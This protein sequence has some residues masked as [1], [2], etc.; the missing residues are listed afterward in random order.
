MFG[1]IPQKSLMGSFLY[2]GCSALLGITV[3]ILSHNTDGFAEW[4]ANYIYPAF[5][6]TIGRLM[7]PIPFSV[8]E[9]LLYIATLIVVVYL[10]Y[11]LGLLVVP[12]FRYGLKK[13]LFR[14]LRVFLIA[15]CTL[16]MLAS[17]TTLVHY[18]RDTFADLTEREIAPAS[19]EALLELG[20]ILIADLAELEEEI[21]TDRAGR[22]TLGTLDYRNESR[23]AM[24]RIRNEHQSLDGFY[25]KPKP[26]FFSSFMSKMGLTGMFSPFTIEANYNAHVPDYIIPFTIC[27]ELAHVRGFLR[28][29][30]AGFIAYLACKRSPEPEFRYS[31]ALNALTYVLRAYYR[32]AT[33][34]EY[35]A[36]LAE[37]PEQAAADIAA[38][39]AYWREFRGR[40]SD[41]ANRANDAYLRVNA[42]NDGV[43]SYGRMIDLLLAEYRLSVI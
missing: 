30:E 11:L 33:I 7:S 6:D 4:Y 14:G 28:E 18:G 10:I 29:D 34:S 27:H 1:K 41:F 21:A 3:L 36:L 26:V 43:R 12:K 13:A 23:E 16:F 37:I 38:N 17:L 32:V 5:P 31:G 15:G 42:Q 9:F 20:M 25:P 35:N 22:F 40:A 8:Y 2:C 19:K 39:N 24:R